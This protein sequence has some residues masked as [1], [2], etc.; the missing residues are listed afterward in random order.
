MGPPPSAV[1][2]PVGDTVKMHETVDVAKVREVPIMDIKD[3][4][5]AFE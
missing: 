2:P 1:L 5:D 4:N 3:W